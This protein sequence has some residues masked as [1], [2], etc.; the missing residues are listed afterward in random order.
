MQSTKQMTTINNL[1]DL[2]FYN[3]KIVNKE[4]IQRFDDILKNYELKIDK[5]IVD[6]L[7]NLKEIQIP[8]NFT[9]EQKIYCQKL[10]EL[11]EFHKQSAV[12]CL[13]LPSQEIIPK[14]SE[15][16]QKIISDDSNIQSK[17]QNVCNSIMNK[18]LIDYPQ[19]LEKIRQNIKANIE[20]D[21]ILKMQFEVLLITKKKC[22]C[23]P[24]EQD[25]INL[26][27]DTN[28]AAI[29]NLDM[30][31]PYYKEL[32]NKLSSIAQDIKTTGWRQEILEFLTPIIKLFSS[33]LAQEIEFNKQSKTFKKL[34]EEQ[35]KI[36]STVTCERSR[37]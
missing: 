1:D 28:K 10:K 18:Q 24:W 5:E 4:G 3:I 36:R 16:I 15:M 25:F 32:I 23:E 21:P 31:I 30:E 8:K 29:K 19:E 37:F 35:S 13:D 34:L 22:S 9:Q 11:I 27:N 33:T 2:L 20:K 12:V 7:V 26:F 14:A 17:R 6:D